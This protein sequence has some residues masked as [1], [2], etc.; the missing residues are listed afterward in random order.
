M[1]DL[2]DGINNFPDPNTPHLPVPLL[3]DATVP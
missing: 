3:E 2:Q 1:S